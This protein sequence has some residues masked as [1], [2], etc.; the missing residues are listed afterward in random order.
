M[1]LM[2]T[3]ITGSTLNLPQT[4][5]VY[6]TSLNGITKNIPVGTPVQVFSPM[7]VAL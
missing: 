6:N 4:M 5:T 1:V 7:V 2:V 3:N